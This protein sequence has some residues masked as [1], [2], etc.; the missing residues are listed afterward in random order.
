[1]LS[2]FQYCQTGIFDQCAS[3]SQC[4]YIIHVFCILVVPT[5]RQPTTD[6]GAEDVNDV[7]LVSS[8]IAAAVAVFAAIA[9][10]L[11]LVAVGLVV[12]LRERKSKMK[13]KAKNSDQTIT[14]K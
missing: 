14:G 3:L 9:V 1:M 12:A 4:A 10:V 6:E 8:V 7:V 13:K 11:L 5:P 2:V